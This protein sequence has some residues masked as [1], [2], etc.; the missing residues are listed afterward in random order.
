MAIPTAMTALTTVLEVTTIS[1]PPTAA[2]PEPLTSA[3][4][5]SVKSPGESFAGMR[6]KLFDLRLH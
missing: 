4:L 6:H 5:P 3:A 1:P 2:I